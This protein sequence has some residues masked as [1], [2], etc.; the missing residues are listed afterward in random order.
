MNNPLFRDLMKAVFD[1]LLG[2]FAPQAHTP[3]QK[4][5]KFIACRSMPFRAGE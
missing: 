1:R 4:R 5:E 3:D 2:R